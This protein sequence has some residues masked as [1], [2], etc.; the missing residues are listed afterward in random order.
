MAEK[1]FIL[2]DI[3]WSDLGFIHN[4]VFHIE[5]KKEKIHLHK[6]MTDFNMVE[7]L[8]DQGVPQSD[9]VISVLQEPTNLSDIQLGEAA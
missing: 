3:G 8:T 1:H 2:M 7:A 9:I 4:W 5:I 6:N